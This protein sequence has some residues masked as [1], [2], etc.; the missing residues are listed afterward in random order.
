MF[1]YLIVAYLYGIPVVSWMK[2]KKLETLVDPCQTL[3]P[4]KATNTL[5][6]IKV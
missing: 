5:T 2:L 6:P 4:A 1:V 3:D